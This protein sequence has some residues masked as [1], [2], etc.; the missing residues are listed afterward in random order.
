MATL[1]VPKPS[2][3]RGWSASKDP[4]GGHSW[5]E[6]KEKWN[7]PLHGSHVLKQLQRSHLWSVEG[8]DG[9]EGGSFRE[10]G[11]VMC[12]SGDRERGG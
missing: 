11:E 12:L 3:R 6:W 5:A 7:Q 10:V 1:E 4:R 9:G 2:A 8:M